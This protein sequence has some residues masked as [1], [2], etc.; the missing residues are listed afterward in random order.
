MGRIGDIGKGV[1]KQKMDVTC[2]LKGEKQALIGA[3][4]RNFTTDS[5]SFEDET[6]LAELLS[7]KL[8]KQ[9]QLKKEWK[10]VVIEKTAERIT[11]GK[12][13]EPAII[14]RMRDENLQPI[15]VFRLFPDDAF[16]HFVCQETRRYAIFR[17]NH[18]FDVSP[19]EMYKYF[20]IL[21]FWL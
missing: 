8:K 18:D 2:I 10:E 4:S 15:D 16:I 9:R 6:P 13:P 12:T 19:Q 17:G 21:I 7:P 20:G 14:D 5:F 11:M 3:G 1:L